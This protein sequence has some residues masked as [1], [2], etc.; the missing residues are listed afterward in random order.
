VSLAAAFAH[1]F[2]SDGR[3]RVL[4]IKLNPYPLHVAKCLTQVWIIT[5]LE[6][7]SYPGDVG[8]G[9]SKAPLAHGGEFGI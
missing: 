1:V 9:S 3:H 8:H 7:D 2:F 4:L 5:A 6:Y